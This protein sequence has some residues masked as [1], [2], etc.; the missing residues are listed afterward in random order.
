MAYFND[1]VFDSG[2][3]WVDAQ[4]EGETLAILNTPAATRTAAVAATIGT[5]TGTKVT[6]TAPA[7]YTGA[8]GG[9]F[10]QIGAITDGDITS[11]STAKNWAIYDSTKLVATGALATSAAVSSGAK[12]TL[13]AIDIIIS[14][15]TST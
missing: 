6:C 8:G 15:P 13:T 5:E 10:V 1:T 4:S 12:F 11:T 2:L 9:R 7:N 14:D 3:D